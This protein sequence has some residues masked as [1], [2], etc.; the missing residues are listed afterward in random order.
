MIGV[1]SRRRL[2]F[3][4]AGSDS[5]VLGDAPSPCAEGRVA[6]LT[7]ALGREGRRCCTDLAPNE[8]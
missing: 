5:A 1:I 3:A 6:G 4:E 7:A 8:N 2:G